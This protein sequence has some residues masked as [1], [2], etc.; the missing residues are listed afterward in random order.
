MRR[1]PKGKLSEIFDSQSVVSQRP[2]KSFNG[3]YEY[4]RVIYAAFQKE[5]S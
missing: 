3:Y 2:E 5:F 4:F 1:E